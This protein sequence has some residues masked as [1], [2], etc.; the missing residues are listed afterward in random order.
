MEKI[1][2]NNKDN[3]LFTELNSEESTNIN[4]G[5][6]IFPLP[7][8]RYAFPHFFPR[9]RLTLGKNFG[10]SLF[11]QNIYDMNKSYFS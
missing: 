6:A 8:W 2:L 3:T 4:G 9:P 1:M 11:K 7:N 5:Y 10:K